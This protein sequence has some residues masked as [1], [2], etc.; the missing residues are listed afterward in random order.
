MLKYANDFIMN[1]K[2][3][4]GLYSFPIIKPID[5]EALY[6]LAMAYSEIVTLEE[7]QLSAAFGSA[8]LEAINDLVQE[9]II[10][11]LPLIKRIGIPD[12]FISFAG[13]QDYIR[14]KAGLV[15]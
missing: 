7:H 11:S 5:K 4:W 8:I 10:K 3:D 9:G 12:K 13:T 1:N 6:Q 2:L 14:Q 15:L